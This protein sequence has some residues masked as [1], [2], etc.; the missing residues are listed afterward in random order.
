MAFHRLTVPGYAGG[1]RPGED[2]INNAVSG[3][4]APADA[5]LGA[6]TYSGSY[7]F[8]PGDQ[9]T[10]AAINRGYKALAQNTDALDDRLVQMALDYAAA[11][12]VLTA[13]LATEVAYRTR[14]RVTLITVATLP[15]T[16]LI[17]ENLLFVTASGG[18]TIDLP[19]PASCVGR[20]FFL[21]F[22]RTLVGGTYTLDAN[23]SSTPGGPTFLNFP[24]TGSEGAA[25]KAMPG[26]PYALYQVTNL[27]TQLEFFTPDGANWLVTAHKGTP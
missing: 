14:E 26:F 23:P 19:N 10:G 17:G 4:P 21:Y 11:D 16:L 1:L 12:A 3:V 2:Y 5:A 27:D 15:H 25:I 13:D 20:K 24:G 18:G 22:D 8:A 7:L 9:V 6:G